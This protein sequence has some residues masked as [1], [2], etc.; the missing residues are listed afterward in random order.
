MS[1][2]KLY[3]V[4]T[5][6]G[7]LEDI[8]LRAARILAQ[9]DAIAAED[10]R[11]TA[12]LTNHLD[13]HKPLISYHEHNRRRTGEKLLNM[14][15]DGKQVA[16]VSDAGMPAVSDPGSELVAQAR[17]RGIEVDVIPGPCAVSAA[18][19]LSGFDGAAYV[20]AGFLPRSGTRRKQAMD[21]LRGE[22]RTMVLYEA[23]HRLAETL[24]ELAQLFGAE[25]PAAVC[26]DITKMYQRV[27]QLPLGQAAEFFA[28]NPPKGEFAL[29]LAGV[30]PQQAGF[31]GLDVAEHVLMYMRQ[32]YDK[33]EAMR[34]TAQDRGVSRR[35][36][37]AQSM[38]A[39]EE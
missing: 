26:N 18:L 22:T 2:G 5:P 32:G 20:F 27:W 15:A 3:L 4:G 34:R 29:V 35:E 17:Q 13:I 7:N 16:L 8:T 12:K 37:Y 11:R 21:T 6:I 25:H 33:K 9:V 28:Q 24:G 23:P 38:D 1:Q 14:M 10:T 30:Q 39:D 36:I 31:E 19:A